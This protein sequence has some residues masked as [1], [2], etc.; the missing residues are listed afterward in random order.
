MG[1][2]LGKGHASPVPPDQIQ[3]PPGR[4]FYLSH[5]P[6]YHNTKKTIRVV[7]D[8]SC[9]FDGVSLNKVILPGPDLMN[10]LIG[11]LMRFRKE[12]VAVMCDV[13]QMFHSFHVNPEH[14]NFLRFLWFENNNP[15]ARI[16]EYRMNFHLF[17][18][19]PSLAVAT[20]GLRATVNDGEEKCSEAVRQFVNR[21]FYVDDGL[22]S[23][24]ETTQG[25]LKFSRSRPI[26]PRR[27]PGEGS[28]G[29]RPEP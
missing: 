19:G 16:I 9:E 23:K 6:T 15:E 24:P 21:N 26:L 22:V 17:G 20:F 14:R 2:V 5:F 12:E 27:R 1:K 7:F 4:L 10:N 13:E 29:P 18:N 25:G 28:Q 11:V 8:S 3:A